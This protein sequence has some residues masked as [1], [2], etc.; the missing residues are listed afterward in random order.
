MTGQIDLGL[1]RGGPVINA[2]PMVRITTAPAEEPRPAVAKASYTKDVV[3]LLNKYCV[4]CHSTEK[5]RAG[6]ALDRFKDDESAA[7]D[8]KFWEKVL[9]QIRSG[10]MRSASRGVYYPNTANTARRNFARPGPAHT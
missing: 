8:H 9:V 10:E 2:G 6:I 1:K 3:P 7:R 4:G 5:K